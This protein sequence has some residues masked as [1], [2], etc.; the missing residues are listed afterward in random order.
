[1][2]SE[3]PGS[4]SSRQSE[5]AA[6]FQRAVQGTRLQMKDSAYF[7]WSRKV[8]AKLATGMGWS[9]SVSEIWREHDNAEEVYKEMEEQASRFH[10]Y[11]P[12]VSADF[13]RDHLCQ[14]TLRETG[15]WQFFLEVL[16]ED[17]VV[18]LPTVVFR[19]RSGELWVLT[20]RTSQRIQRLHSRIVVRVTDDN[21][22]VQI[23]TLDL[24]L[25]EN[26]DGGC[27]GVDA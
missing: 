16:K 8:F 5:F 20:L 23:M 12:T 2:S 17:P 18:Y 4:A 13:F 6:R 1:M 10:L 3:S 19:M 21:P 26:G 25:K 9:T 15:L 27:S 22:D 7:V 24:F 11:F 14:D